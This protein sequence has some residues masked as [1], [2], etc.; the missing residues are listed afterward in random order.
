MKFLDIAS[1]DAVSG[2]GEGRCDS[3]LG[4]KMLV[5][6][7]DINI[8]KCGDK[9]AD[10]NMRTV[11]IGSAKEL[12]GMLSASLFG[13]LISD[14]TID[15]ELIERANEKE[16][17]IFFNASALAGE[18]QKERVR[19]AIS[20]KRLLRYLMHKKSRIAIATFAKSKEDLLSS[21]QLI[22]L[23][24]FIGAPEETAKAMISYK[25]S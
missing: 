15:K 24:K 11:L 5:I 6:G 21:R 8:R 3:V 22:A 10:G 2:M 16:L 12:S 4:M 18:S 20:M 25:I 9:H 7:K 1:A 23:S 13:I 14:N 19:R 17:T